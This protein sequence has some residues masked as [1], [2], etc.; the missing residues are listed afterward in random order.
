MAA[1]YDAYKTLIC[2]SPHLFHRS[3][4]LKEKEVSFSLRHSADL[5]K[6]AGCISAELHV[7][8]NLNLNYRKIILSEEIRILF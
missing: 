5:L 8:K 2:A 4:G 1:V 7:G 6:M 3:Q